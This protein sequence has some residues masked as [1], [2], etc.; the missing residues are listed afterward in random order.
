MPEN[1]R[2]ALDAA[3]MKFQYQ[4]E[5]QPGGFRVAATENRAPVC[6]ELTEWHWKVTHPGGPE[7]QPV[8]LIRTPVLVGEIA[9]AMCSGWQPQNGRYARWKTDRRIL[10]DARAIYRRVETACERL[11]DTV[12]DEVLATQRAVFAATFTNGPDI[13]PEL[14]APEFAALRR[15]I[16]AYRAASAALVAGTDTTDLRAWAEIESAPEM[17]AVTALA[18]AR[19]LSLIISYSGWD[20]EPEARAR[21]FLRRLAGGWMGLFSPDGRQYRPLNR[22]LMNLP[23]GVPPHLLMRLSRIRLERPVTD[24]AVLIALL[25]AAPELPWAPQRIQPPPW[26]TPD[27]RRDWSQ[28]IQH[29]THAQVTHAMAIAG[30]AMHRT[31]SPRR[32]GDILHAVRWITDYPGEH[33]GSITGL[34]RKSARWHR[35]QMQAEADKAIAELGGDRKTTVPPVPLPAAEGVEFLAT[36]ARVAYEGPQMNHCAASYAQAA[37]AG[38]CYL[39]HVEHGGEHATVEVLPQGEV[40]QVR[41]P[42]NRDNG[43]CRYGRRV[44][45]RWGRQFR[46]VTA[47]LPEPPP[48]LPAPYPR[49]AEARVPPVF[50]RRYA[51]V[52][53]WA[54]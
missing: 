35:E 13:G 21:Y 7:A 8:A 30:V 51:P 19:G 25:A 16:R 42:G 46:D 12:P 36:V 11:L 44:L 34:A 9:R 20:A 49:W 23:G 40:G 17:E 48:G 45:A 53:P 2:A 4:I 29:A 43:A 26:W 1:D 54:Q 3:A 10:L 24:R 5:P 37:V 32:T 47:D 14:Y 22:T 31:L 6:V 39:F 27:P 28:I 38:R 52:P 18:A 50:P 33:H 41:G 15:D